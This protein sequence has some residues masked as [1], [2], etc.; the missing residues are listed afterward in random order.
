ML[1]NFEHLD[2]TF[3]FVAVVGVQLGTFFC[4]RTPPKIRM[5]AY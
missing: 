1:P 4:S 5:K 2:L 3:P